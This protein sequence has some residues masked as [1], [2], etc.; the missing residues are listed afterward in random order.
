MRLTNA[1]V[2]E[3][4]LASQVLVLLRVPDQRV[5][6]CFKYNVHVCMLAKRRKQARE[7]SSLEVVVSQSHSSSLC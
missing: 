1:C 2:P 5:G 3:A 6:H 7:G 4:E